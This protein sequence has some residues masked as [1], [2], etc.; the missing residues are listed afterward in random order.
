MRSSLG[1]PIEPNEHGVWSAVVIPSGKES[2][3]REYLLRNNFTF[4]ETQLT[5]D[6]DGHSEVSYLFCF[7]TD[8]APLAKKILD[9]LE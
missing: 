1:D 3:F 9:G 7:P 6:H 8:W 4:F 2:M 5:L